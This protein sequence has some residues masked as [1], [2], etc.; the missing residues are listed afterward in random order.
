[1]DNFD[2]VYTFKA[3]ELP[4]RTEE[5]GLVRFGSVTPK[6][7]FE[8][9]DQWAAALA[10]HL[11]RA[12]EHLA[13][14]NWLATEAPKYKPPQRVSKTETARVTI[15]LDHDNVVESDFSTARRAAGSFNGVYPSD[16]AYLGRTGNTGD[17][18]AQHVFE[19]TYKWT[20]F[21]EVPA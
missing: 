4:K 19:V 21:A 8:D 14:Y 11:D 12:L 10:V 3:S 9:M 16:T 1:M 20:D 5:P 2:N 7:T 13:A 6:Q 17:G 18:R 15:P